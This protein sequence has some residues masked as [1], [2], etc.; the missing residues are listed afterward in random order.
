MIV[1]QF[2]L[3]IDPYRVSPNFILSVMEGL[4]LTI[5]NFL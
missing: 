5:I 2:Q 4:L 3:S 1:Y